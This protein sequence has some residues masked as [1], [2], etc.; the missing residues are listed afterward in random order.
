[1]FLVSRALAEKY[2]LYQKTFDFTNLYPK[3]YPIL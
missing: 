2:F 3:K 1:M